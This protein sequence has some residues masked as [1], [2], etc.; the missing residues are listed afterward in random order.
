MEKYKVKFQLKIVPAK[1]NR[2]YHNDDFYWKINKIYG[3]NCCSGM[4][5]TKEM[6]RNESFFVS[7]NASKTEFFDLVGVYTSYT[8]LERAVTMQ[9]S[10]FKSL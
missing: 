10:I 3:W 6:L 5:S 2:K 7:I 1:S 4:K 9:I 8:E